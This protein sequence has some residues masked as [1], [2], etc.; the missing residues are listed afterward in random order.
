MARIRTIKPQFFKNEQLADLPMSTRLLFIG[1]WTLADKEGRFE[2]RPKRIKAEL[3]PYDNIDVDKEISRL[4]SAG[5]IERYE[6]GELKVIQVSTFT[7]HQKIT[8]KEAYT[9]SKYPPPLGLAKKE[10]TGK[11]GETPEKLSR[12]QGKEGNEERNKE[13]KGESSPQFNSTLPNEISNPPPGSAAPPSTGPP[14][15]DVDRWFRGAGGT[16]EMAQKFYNKWDAVGWVQNGS[17]IVRWA[18]LAGNFIKNYHD[19]EDGRKKRIESPKPGTIAIPD[20]ERS[21]GSL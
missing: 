1:L 21:Y 20:G 2:D 10:I 17:R 4:Q 18:S 9:T 3:F 11:D 7:E 5:F 15:E 12:S 6:V 8:G 19:N 16:T 14:F 13:G